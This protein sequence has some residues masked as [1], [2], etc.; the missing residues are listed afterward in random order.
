MSMTKYRINRR[1][2]LGLIGSAAS[3]V[4]VPGARVSAQTLDKVSYL[5]NWRAQAEHGGFYLAAT[6]GI[7]KKHGLEVNLRPGG[8]Q[9]NHAQLLAAGV[10][11]FNIASNSFV[12]LNFVREQIPMV[13]V[14]APRGV[15][16]MRSFAQAAATAITSTSLR[17][18]ATTSA[19]LPCSCRL[20]TG[21]YQK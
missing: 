12:P 13:A 9:V 8:P 7:Y 17:G 3:L 16:G 11:D 21:E 14:A 4:A 6:N 2:A 19:D 1:K 18:V 15:S 10:L 20:R 5:T